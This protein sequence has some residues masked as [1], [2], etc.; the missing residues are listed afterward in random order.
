MGR[1]VV[2]DVDRP[3]R[4]AADVAGE[5][6]GA[7]AQ[8][9]DAVAEAGGV[10]R[11]VTRAGGQAGLHLGRPQLTADPGDRAGVL[12]EIDPG[13]VE[14]RLAEADT[15]AGR[16]AA[17]EIDALA[18]AA[19]PAVADLAGDRGVEPGVVFDRDR[20]RPQAG[21]RSVHRGSTTWLRPWR[22]AAGLRTRLSAPRSRRRTR[23]GSTSV[24]L[25]AAK[26]SKAAVAGID[27]EALL[28]PIVQGVPPGPPHLGDAG[29]RGSGPA[30][31]GEA[32]AG[33]GA[34]AV[35]GEALEVGAVEGIGAGGRDAVGVGAELGAAGR[36]RPGRRRRRRTSRTG[37]RRTCRPAPHRR[38]AAAPPPPARSPSPRSVPI[39]P[40]CPTS[41]PRSLVCVGGVKGW[42]DR[43]SPPW[44]RIGAAAPA[45]LRE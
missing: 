19:P 5:I 38:S 29:A 44:T 18:A 14:G 13:A 39:R 17:G 25:A 23:A 7:V 10:D 26:T 20:Q 36:V 22:R 41:V 15:G 16:V 9:V 3:A 45:P 4:A 40:A 24:P 35:A 31:A 37:R 27:A 2:V 33:D 28:D 8:L 32:G 1:R 43:I 34:L 6:G 11:D 12:G 21:P 30:P 42:A